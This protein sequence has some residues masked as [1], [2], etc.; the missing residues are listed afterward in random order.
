MPQTQWI[1]HLP[2]IHRRTYP[3]GRVAYLNPGTV[4]ATEE[5]MRAALGVESP[6]YELLRL[7]NTL[8]GADERAQVQ[9]MMARWNELFPPDKVIPQ[10]WEYEA[11]DPAVQVVVDGE[12][13]FN[14]QCPIH[15]PSW[16]W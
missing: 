14:V 3:N 10:A 8:D 11:I 1:I 16:D 6:E 2:V 15:R 13:P 5:M 12:R 4:D 9:P 7:V